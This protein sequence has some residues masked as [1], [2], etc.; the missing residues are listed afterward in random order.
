M[1]DNIHKIWGERRRILINDLVEIDHLVIKKDYC[2]SVHSH[3]HKSN[4]FYVISGKILVKTELGDVVLG[5]NEVFDVHAPLKHQFIALEDSVL[6][7]CAYIQ[8]EEND[9]VRIKQGGKMIEGI[10]VTEDELKN[11]G[12]LNL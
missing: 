3:K 12:E 6:V 9:I 4:K 8:I 2:C 1:N 5:T 11:R 7:E 10:H